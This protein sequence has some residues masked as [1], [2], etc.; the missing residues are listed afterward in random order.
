MTKKNT[1]KLRFP[2]FTDEWEEKKLKDMTNFISSGKTKNK[3]QEGK[4]NVYGSRGIIGHTNT[5]DYVGKFILI[6]RVGA[7]AGDLF[8]INEKCGISDN[9]L[10]IEL[11][12]GNIAE[13]YLHLLKNFNLHRLIFGS[14]QPLITGKQLKNS[15]LNFPNIDEQKKIANFLSKVDE[16]ITLLEEKLELFNDFKKFCMQQLFAQKLR[17]EN[18]SGEYWVEKKIG[19]V[20]NCLDNKRKPLNQQDRKK[21][22]GNIPYY[23]ANGIV[24]YVNDYI[25]NE[26][27][28]LLAE[29]GG[30]FEEFRSKPIAQLID[31]KSWVN[32][33]AHVLINKQGL[34]IEFLFYS[35]VHKDV[36]KYINGTSRSKLNK[37]EM[38]S[39]KISVPTLKEQQKIVIFLTSIDNKIDKLIIEL[40]TIQKFK[41]FLLQQMFV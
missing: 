26:K 34:L 28:V 2:E 3:Q 15:L 4:Y 41:K 24:D 39:I 33:H 7:N 19:E 1:P 27:I 38:L 37:K 16:K 23:G 18:F 9:T 25:F 29:D 14:G 8:L 5:P 12:L 13:F 36:R 31:G 21:I 40:E 20:A 11:S 17:F 35:L 30:H 22:K 32:N 10:I 6:A